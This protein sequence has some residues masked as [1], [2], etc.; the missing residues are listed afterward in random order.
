MSKATL[1]V[2]QATGTFKNA[3]EKTNYIELGVV[4]E[5]EKG[6]Q[7]MKL[8]ALPLPNEKG[9]VW[10]SLFPIKKESAPKK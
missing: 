2:V 6:Y 3:K 9:E 5:N 1:K 8:N 7:S 4:I 10:L